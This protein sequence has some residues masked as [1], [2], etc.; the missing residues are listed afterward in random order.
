M[1]FSLLLKKKTAV[2]QYRH[3]YIK[4]QSS[5]NSFKLKVLSIEKVRELLLSLE[6][7]MVENVWG[8][9]RGATVK[10]ILEQS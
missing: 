8:L 10:A 5:F 9:L 4:C 6:H 7:Q 1:I 2:H 3:S